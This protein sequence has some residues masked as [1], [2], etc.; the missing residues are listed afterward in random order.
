MNKTAMIMTCI[1]STG[2]IALCNAQGQGTKQETDVRK[3]VELLK[4]IETGDKEPAGNIK[5]DKYIQHNL[6]VANGIEGFGAL[7]AQLADYPEPPT[8]NTVRAFQDGNYVFAQ[9]DYNF[10][11]PKIGIDIFRFE[12][13]KIVEH[14]DNLMTTPSSPNPSGR[15]AIDG[16]TA[17]A[18]LDKTAANKALAQQ[19]VEDVL[20]QRHADNL[21]AYFDGDKLVQHDPQI[22]D[23]A[24]AY[25]AGLS[26]NGHEYKYANVEKVLG[27]GNFVL[28]VSQGTDNGIPV[29]YYDLYR[30]EDGKIAEHWDVIET[31]P[32]KSEWKN[33][34]GKFGFA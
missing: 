31:I 34:N 3:A 21:G 12:D 11:G 10:F 20:I 1:A 18:D 17:I 22:G 30:I 7:L 13:G 14:W 2:S 28:V 15:T 24:N 6:D 26:Q 9:T 4:S 27:Q 8:V 25:L 33:P 23:G 29:A 5:A 19:F 32:P 16:A